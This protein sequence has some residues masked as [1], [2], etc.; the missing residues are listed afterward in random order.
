M[1]LESGTSLQHT[2]G[3]TRDMLRMVRYLANTED[4]P[5]L[6]C[7]LSNVEDQVK[8]WST[9]FPSIVPTHGTKLTEMIIFLTHSS[10]CRGQLVW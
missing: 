10:R 1:R 3:W 5:F 8:L 6:V 2:V 4:E 7:S 9:T